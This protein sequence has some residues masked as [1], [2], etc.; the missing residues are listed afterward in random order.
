MIQ[1][2]QRRNH[3]Q[4]NKKSKK[5]NIDGRKDFAGKGWGK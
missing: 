5:R 4:K 3:V 2:G 1:I